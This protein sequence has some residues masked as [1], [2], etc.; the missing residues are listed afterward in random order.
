MLPNP[1]FCKCVD[2]GPR[3][4]EFPPDPSSSSEC[5]LKSR[6]SEQLQPDQINIISKP[7]SNVLRIARKNAVCVRHDGSFLLEVWTNAQSRKCSPIRE[8]GEYP[9]G[10]DFFPLPMRQLVILKVRYTDYPGRSIPQHCG[11]CCV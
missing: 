10:P 5:Q 3:N 9:S 1:R 7:S 4:R 6:D 2:H 8:I 11:C